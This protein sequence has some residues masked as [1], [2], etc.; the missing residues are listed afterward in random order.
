MELAPVGSSY[1]LVGRCYLFREENLEVFLIKGNCGIKA[2]GTWLK[3]PRDFWS[4]SS[5]RG[6]EMPLASSPQPLRCAGASTKLR[7]SIVGWNF[8]ADG[9]NLMARSRGS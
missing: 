4:L 5:K 9:L 8:D 3:D 2:E 7:S 1:V 6:D